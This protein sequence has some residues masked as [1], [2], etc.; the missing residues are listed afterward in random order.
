MRRVSSWGRLS[1]LPHE[2]IELGDRSRVAAELARGRPGHRLRP[3]AQLRRCVPQPR[4]R[5]VAHGRARPLHPFRRGERPAGLRG[6]GG[7]ARHPAPGHSARLGPAG[8]AGHPVR[9]RGRR[10][11]QR[12]ARQEPSRDRHLR[13]S[14]EVAPAAAHRRPG[15]RV[16][17]RGA[18]RLVRRDRGRSR[19]DRPHRRGR[20]AAPPAARSVARHRD[21]RLFRPRRI[22]PPVRGIASRLGA[23]RLLDRLHLGR[24]RPRPVPARQADRPASTEP[25]ASGGSPCRWCRRSRWSTG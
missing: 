13:R 25:G 18:A 12:R 1:A 17:S 15:D 21:D 6:G 22:L 11:R 5:A 20:A 3:G 14:C 2:V 16:R 19:P 24:C 7:A 8:A 23:R 9:H 10:H 4:R